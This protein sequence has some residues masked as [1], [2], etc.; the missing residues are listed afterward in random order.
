MIQDMNFVDFY[1]TKQKLRQIDLMDFNFSDRNTFLHVYL[2][3][4]MFH[5]HT[6]H[7]QDKA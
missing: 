2:S 4:Q 1:D 5:S 6:V 3:A 7:S